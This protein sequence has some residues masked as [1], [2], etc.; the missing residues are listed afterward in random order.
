MSYQEEFI[1]IANIAKVIDES[2]DY[3]TA[4]ESLIYNRTPDLYKRHNVFYRVYGDEENLI[5]TFRY[6]DLFNTSDNCIR[7]QD[8]TALILF[9][10]EFCTK[11][12]RDIHAEIPKVMERDLCS[13]PAILT[14]ALIGMYWYMRMCLKVYKDYKMEHDEVIV[15]MLRDFGNPGCLYDTMIRKEQSK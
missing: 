14:T 5:G 2:R 10:P 4:R 3:H 6:Y 11:L 13:D 1:P 7:L 9:T 12:R 8:D 15:F